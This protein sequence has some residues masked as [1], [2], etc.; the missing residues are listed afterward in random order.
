[1][2]AV[3]FRL[4]RKVGDEYALKDAWKNTD[5]PDIV[6][7]NIFNKSKDSFQKQGL[8]HTDPNDLNSTKN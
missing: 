8:I 7:H 1:M 4:E 6:F 2:L 5:I 3:D